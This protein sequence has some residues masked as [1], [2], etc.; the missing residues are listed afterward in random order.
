M[1]AG[2]N[3]NRGL[4]KGSSGDT[5]FLG[6]LLPSFGENIGR[7]REFRSMLI[8]SLKAV[9]DTRMENTQSCPF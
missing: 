3:I 1:R 9:H 5:V 4:P 2:K 6:F 7:Q 8:D